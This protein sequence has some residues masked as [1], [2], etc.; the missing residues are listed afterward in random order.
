VTAT[1]ASTPFQKGVDRLF[2]DHPI[3][4]PR[5][6]SVDW[7]GATR[8]KVRLPGFP[9]DQMPAV[10][11]NKFKSTM[12]EKIAALATSERTTGDVHLELIDEN[13]R[14]MDTLDAKE[15]IGAFAEPPQG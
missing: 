10:V 12:N 2:A 15:L 4:G 13:G 9:M 14:V 3:V 5:V 7:T 1:N 6:A 11:R 8:A